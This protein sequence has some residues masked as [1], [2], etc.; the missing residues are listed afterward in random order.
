MNSEKDS[1]YKWIVTVTKECLNMIKHTPQ[2]ITIICKFVGNSSSPKDWR[3]CRHLTIKSWHIFGK[4]KH[5]KCYCYCFVKVC[6]KLIC[7]MFWIHFQREKT[8]KQSK[9]KY[10]QQTP[11]TI[12]RFKTA[13]FK[14]YCLI[15]C[16]FSI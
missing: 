15:H 3:R 5:T 12:K 13:V 4:Y 1:A 14:S 7:Y 9:K 6:N 8:N 2:K 16:L 10:Q 11:T